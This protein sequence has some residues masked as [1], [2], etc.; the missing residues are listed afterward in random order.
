MIDLGDFKAGATLD[1]M[2]DSNGQDGASITRSTDGALRVYKANSATQRSSSAGITDS[3]DFD[4]L[5]GVHHLRIDLSDNTDA[6]FYA[7]GSTYHV[8]LVGAVIDTKTVNKVLYRFSIEARSG[9]DFLRANHATAS[10]FGEVETALGIADA[11][12]DE[13]TSGHATAGTTGKAVSDIL[14]AVDTEIATLITNVASIL[15]AVD[16]EVAAIKAK[17]DNLPAAPAAVGDVPTANANADALLDRA[18]GVETSWT[19]RQAMRILLA[20]SAGK[21]SGA[22]GTTVAIRDMADSKDRISATVDASG[23]RSAV[24]RDA[25]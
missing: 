3:E 10:T 14:A 21:V 4:A 19:L 9:W 1:A 5:T 12:W 16:T 18:A 11:V 6:G 24:T 23:N 2:W 25:S 22:G 17:T 8:V 13:A 15:A 20:A 7:V